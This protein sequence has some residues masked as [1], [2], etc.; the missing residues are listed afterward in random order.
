M[1]VSPAFAAQ[2]LKSGP[3][4]GESIPGPFH[5]VNLNGAHASNP[6]CL[7]CEFGMAPVV[8]VFTRDIGKT[9]ALL[10]K[11]DE[12]IAG[13]AGSGLKA[14]AVV[15]SENFAK[16]ESREEVERSLGKTAAKLKNVILAVMPAAG[17]EGYNIAKDADITVILYKKLKVVSSFAFAKDQLTDKEIGDI[18]T[19]TDKLAAP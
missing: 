4:P 6:H 16:P 13:R 15:L 10:E 3:Q 14:F 18:L 11:L 7:V 8:L 9:G 2:A 5:P 17:P 19:A 12:A 1:F